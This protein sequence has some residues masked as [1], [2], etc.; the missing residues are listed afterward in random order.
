M[1][2]TCLSCRVLGHCPGI[3]FNYAAGLRGGSV[4]GGGGAIG[5]LN[6]VVG[7]MDE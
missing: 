3:L 7:L 4:G 1:S 5:G 2:N 6:S